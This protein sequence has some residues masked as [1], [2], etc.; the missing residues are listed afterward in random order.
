M[1]F[2]L[3]AFCYVPKCGVISIYVVPIK[4]KMPYISKWTEYYTVQ[5]SRDGEYVTRNA[6]FLALCVFFR[7]LHTCVR[8][9]A[10]N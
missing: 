5:K 9:L 6:E 3:H 7:G 10:I 4:T 2:Y 1:D 8:S